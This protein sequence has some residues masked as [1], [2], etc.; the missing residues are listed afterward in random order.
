MLANTAHS[1]LGSI[2]NTGTTPRRTKWHFAQSTYNYV[3][4][5]LTQPRSCGD[6]LTSLWVLIQEIQFSS[7][8]KSGLRNSHGHVCGWDEICATRHLS[9]GSSF[10]ISHPNSIIQIH[11]SHTDWE[12]IIHIQLTGTICT[13]HSAASLCFNPFYSK[14]YQKPSSSKLSDGGIA[15]ESLQEGRAGLA[16]KWQTRVREQP[17][18]QDLFTWQK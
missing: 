7:A 17:K 15:I 1:I 14:L 2:E 5:C 13:P 11:W 12:H 8:P 16:L 10:K 6:L 9:T 18:H 4:V 3:S